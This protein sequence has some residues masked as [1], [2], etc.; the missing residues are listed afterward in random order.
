MFHITRKG[1]EREY[2]RKESAHVHFQR[3]QFS[4]YQRFKYSIRR[5]WKFFWE[6]YVK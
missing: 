3:G 5:K 4:G 1:A 6:V 2:I